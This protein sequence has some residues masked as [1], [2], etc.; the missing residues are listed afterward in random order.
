MIPT[1]AWQ[2][3]D[4][5]GDVTS[6][7]TFVRFGVGVLSDGATSTPFT[8]GEAMIESPIHQRYE[9]WTGPHVSDPSVPGSVNITLHG[10]GAA[11]ESAW[12]NRS[13]FL[14]DTAG[15]LVPKL[16]LS[17]LTT[18]DTWMARAVARES[19]LGVEPQ[20][21]PPP[22]EEP[23]SLVGSVTKT[24]DGVTLWLPDGVRV[25]RPVRDGETPEKAAERLLE[26][27]GDYVLEAMG[28]HR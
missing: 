19:V 18:G 21:G 1:Q 2:W 15:F 20:P 23:L 3:I 8:S 24:G 25:V 14:L 12:I 10:I 5:R 17:A 16:F 4:T 6:K 28:A 22:K 26:A 13:T 27:M 9:T 7:Y 11:P